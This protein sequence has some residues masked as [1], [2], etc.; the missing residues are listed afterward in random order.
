MTR[1]QRLLA[2]TLITGA[3]IGV[4]APAASAAT[5]APHAATAAVRTVDRAPAAVSHT[6]PTSQSAPA[7]AAAAVDVRAGVQARG[8]S[9]AAKKL[10]E[11][12]AKSKYGKK[13]IAAAKKGRNSFKSWVNGLSNFNPLK[14]AIKAAPAY[15]LDEVISYLVNHF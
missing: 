2:A 11:K 8:I 13:A 14:W 9:S 12:I 3:L 6:A 4:G 5:A 10:A 1:G 15:I 7:S